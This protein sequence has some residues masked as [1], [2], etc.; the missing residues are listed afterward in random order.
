MRRGVSDD[1]V[2]R[3]ERVTV[4]PLER[5]CAERALAEPTAVADERVG[6]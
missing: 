2:G 5:A 3:A 1:E 6:K 4:D